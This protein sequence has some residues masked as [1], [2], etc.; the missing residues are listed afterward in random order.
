MKMNRTFL[1]VGFVAALQIGALGQPTNS[2]L[3][4]S[5]TNKQVVAQASKTQAEPSYPA[6]QY[7]VVEPKLAEKQ[8]KDKIMRLGPVSS[9]AW[10]TI[11]SQQP[12]PTLVHNLSTHEPVV[13]LVS[14]GHEPW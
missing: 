11:A 2:V 9:Q 7:K 10:T 6:M 8:D 4:A 5:T 14:F 1:A 12:N 13:C 3:S